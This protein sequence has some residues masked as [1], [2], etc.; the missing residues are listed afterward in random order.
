MRLAACL[1]AAGLLSAGCSQIVIVPPAPDGSSTAVDV[2]WEKGNTTFGRQGYAFY[3]DRLLNVVYR[4][5]VE[6]IERDFGPALDPMREILAA[7]LPELPHSYAALMESPRGPLGTLTVRIGDGAPVV[8]DRAGQG[9]FIDGYPDRPH[10]IDGQRLARDFGLALAAQTDTLK[11]MQSYLALLEHPEGYK[12]K[13]IYRTQGKEIVLDHAHQGLTLDGMERPVDAAEIERDFGPALAALREILAAGLPE[14]PH[15]QVIL[16]A[17]DMGQLGD[18]S[19]QSLDDGTRHQLSRAADGVFIDGYPD[20]PHPIDKAR[21]QRDFGPTLT[22]LANTLKAMRSYIILLESPD[23]EASKVVYRTRGESI[24]LEHP[25]QSLTLDGLDNAPDEQIAEKDFTPARVSTKQILDEGLPKLPHS[26]VALVLSPAGELGEVE[27]L[28]G[29]AQGVTLNQSW[30]AVIIDGYS[31][32]IHALDEAQYRKDFGDSLAAMPPPP[33]LHYLYFESGSARLTRDS[34]EVIPQILEEI[35]RHPAADV[36]ISGHTDTVGGGDL[37]DRL[38]RKRGEAIAEL[39]LKSGVPTQEISLAAY[40]KAVLAV[41]TP[42]NTPELLNR[43][44]E[45]IIR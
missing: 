26:Y 29:K 42:D 14:L 3:I 34:R 6:D 37:N 45:V 33:V 5:D 17:H 32:K 16:L 18:L 41:D 13:L 38:S 35:R 40:G 44:V 31:D 12:D 10:P 30:Q 2:T 8:L 21:L 27:I 24:Y 43:R 11:A 22:A 36:S 7:G 39:I 9:I 28:E 23:G 19:F 25:G 15:S 4:I 1:L 20:R